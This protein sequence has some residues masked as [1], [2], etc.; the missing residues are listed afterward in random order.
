MMYFN[1]ATTMISIK[2]FKIKTANLT[3]DATV[4]CVVLNRFFSQ[5]I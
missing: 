4:M 5:F 1:K 2:I 3:F